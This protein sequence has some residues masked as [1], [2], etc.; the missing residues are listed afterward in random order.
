LRFALRYALQRRG[1][2]QKRPPVTA[3]AFKI[4]IIYNPSAGVANQAGHPHA[5]NTTI[6][7]GVL[8]QMPLV[9]LLSE[10]DLQGWQHLNVIISRRMWGQTL[11]YGP[12]QAALGI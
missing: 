5:T 3:K 4:H 8:S 1:S 2:K 11:Y 10:I 9:I 7:T 12:Q 6:S